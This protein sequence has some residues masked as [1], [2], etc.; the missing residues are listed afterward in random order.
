MSLTVTEVMLDVV[1]LIFQSVK[2]FVFD[3]PACS[4]GPHQFNNI[5]FADLLVGHP[6]I[7]V[8]DFWADMQ[9]IL[10]K[11]HWIGMA[12]PIERNLVDPT[13]N[14]AS[15]FIVGKLQLPPCPRPTSSSTHWNST[16]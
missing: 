5:V 1:A 14:M 13:I 11:I 15:P 10:E 8:G 9:P 16:L 7:V 4:A 3:F 12:A 6:T 2:G